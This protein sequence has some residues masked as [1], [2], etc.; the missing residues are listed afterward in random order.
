MIFSPSVMGQWPALLLRAV[1]T[2][3]VDPAWAA[4]ADV[5]GRPFHDQ[6]AAALIR[7][8]LAQ[9]IAAVAES[10]ALPSTVGSWQP[11]P[12]AAQLQAAAVRRL[13]VGDAEHPSAV[14]RYAIFLPDQGGPMRLITDVAVSP[15]ADTD[16]R[17]G[18]LAL[19]EVR[20]VLTA[21]LQATAS[22]V[23]E[24]VVRSIY[25]GELAPREAIE[26]YLWSAQGQSNGR[27]TTLATTIDLDQLGST[28]HPGQ[29]AQQGLYAVA[30]DIPTGDIRQCRNLVTHALIRMAMDWGYLDS[31]A[32]IARLASA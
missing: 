30:A 22:E 8:G 24:E 28:T 27:A 16:A 13:I 5:F 23:A 4:Q 3:E 17:W 31:A 26:F 29:P 12:D 6:L 15:T 14:L 2:Y 10:H 9:Q 18:K 32:V 19:T 11:D 1:T 25:S 7:T 21:G 20:D